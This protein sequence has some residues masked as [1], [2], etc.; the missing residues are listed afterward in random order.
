M[1]ASR[2]VWGL[3]WRAA[4][5]RRRLLAWNVGVPVLLLGPVALSS[6]AAPHRAAVFAVF[7]VMFGTFGACIPLVREAEAG[8][9]RKLLLTGC[10]ERGWMAGRLGASVVL[11][12]LQLTP[13]AVLLLLAGGSSTA[14]FG[15][16]PALAL[17][18]VAANVLGVLAAAAVRSLAEGALVCAAL[19]LAALHG[20]GVFRTPE[21]GGLGALSARWSPFAPLHRSLR[22]A[23]VGRIGAGADVASVGVEPWVAAGAAVLA[24][25]AVAPGLAGRLSATDLE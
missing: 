1:N 14:V 21:P 6:A 16:L 18:L 24:V 23:G 13:L 7:I 22:E 15:F 19:A 4:V 8:W 25:A 12:F 5:S 11:D 3:E 17:A 9:T 2:E 10:D 20:T